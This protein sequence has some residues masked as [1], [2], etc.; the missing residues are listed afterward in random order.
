MG[1]RSQKCTGL[2]LKISI[3]SGKMFNLNEGD[4]IYK[5][6]TFKRLEDAKASCLEAKKYQK[7]GYYKKALEKYNFSLYSFEN[8]FGFCA[9][10]SAALSPKTQVFLLLFVVDIVG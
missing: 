8:F 1:D 5:D 4:Y 10:D 2:L 3:W 7:L 9:L 6:T